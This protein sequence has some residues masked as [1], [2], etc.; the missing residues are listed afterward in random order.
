VPVS[1][2]E[3][4]PRTLMRAGTS[5]LEIVPK[6][7]SLVIEGAAIRFA[8][9]GNQLE[10][11]LDNPREGDTTYKHGER[12]VLLVEPPMAEALKN[13]V[14]DVQTGEEGK[15]LTLSVEPPEE[16]QSDES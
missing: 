1:S 9:N 12:V 4:T 8:A 11:R 7:S 14:L 2:N 13:G 10:P 15:Q 3:E 6:A 16:E 5:S